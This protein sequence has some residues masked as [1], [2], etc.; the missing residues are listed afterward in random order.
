MTT[1]SFVT[2]ISVDQAPAE[3]FSAVANPR[4][5]WSEEIEG[6]TAN[7]NDEFTYHYQDVH[8]CRMKLI[9]VIPDQ[10]IVWLVLDNYFNFVQDQTEWK[11]TQIIFE[12]SESDQ[13][14]ELRFTHLGLVPEHECFGIC[15]DAWTSYIQNSLHSLITN[16]VGQPNPKEGA[17]EN[18]PSQSYQTNLTVSASPRKVFECINDVTKWWTENLEGDS[19]ALQSEFAV[20]F[21]DI[22]FSRQKLV[23]HVPYKKVVWLVTESELTFLGNK[24]EWDNTRISF[25]LTSLDEKFTQLHFTHEGLV[26]E[27]ECYDAC[28][29]AWSQYLQGSLAS[30]INTGQGNPTKKEY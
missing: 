30:L 1:T 15:R 9:E 21:G 22:H 10:K 14:T 28:S 5:W 25:E 3:V 18:V 23:E 17:T 11:G 24:Q 2:T 29:N 16:G 13:N 6:G 12:I 8:L 7:L 4:A 19:K 20:R 27:I 26:P